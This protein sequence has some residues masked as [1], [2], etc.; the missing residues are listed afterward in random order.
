MAL[1][2]F[3]KKETQA[4]EV[5]YLEV[6]DAAETAKAGHLKIQVETLGG[7]ADTDRIQAKLRAGDIIWVKIKTLKEKDMTELKRAVDRL[8]KTVM[9][10]EGDI[11]GVD[12][13]YLVLAP[14]GVAVH[15]D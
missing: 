14:K 10:V 15:R 12:E 6:V 2:L 11:A 1:K 5:D 7:F 4:G 9:A 13:D 8:R 3:G